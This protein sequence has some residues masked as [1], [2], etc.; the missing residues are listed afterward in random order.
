VRPSHFIAANQVAEV[1]AAVAPAPGRG[2]AS[3]GGV[4]VAKAGIAQVQRS[5]RLRRC[6]GVP[7]G[8]QDAV[9]TGRSPWATADSPIFR[10]KVPMPHSGKSEV[11]APASNGV[12]WRTILW[13][14]ST[15]S[16]TLTPADRDARQVMAARPW[17]LGPATGDRD[18]PGKRCRT[19]GGG[20]GGGAWSARL[21]DDR[22][23]L[24]PSWVAPAGHGHFGF[25]GPHRGHWSKAITH[26]TPRAI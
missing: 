8:C 11:C 25:A 16:P 7:V 5:P 15:G 18:R 26:R 6:R 23:A 19:W 1:G 13:H 4:V 9:R 3:K 24:Q 12:T 21:L 2:A 22:T 17:G 14:L 10:A 20:G